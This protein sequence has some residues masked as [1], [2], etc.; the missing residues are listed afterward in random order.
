MN[1]MTELKSIVMIKEFQTAVSSI[2]SIMEAV[3][4]SLKSKKRHFK[5]LSQE[6]ADTMAKLKEA[7]AR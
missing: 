1:L 2:S 6:Q 4:N 5:Y 3:F 7:V